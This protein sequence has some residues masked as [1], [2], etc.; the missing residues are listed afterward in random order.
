[1]EST[2]ERILGKFALLIEVA[3]YLHE[4]E[5]MTR[6]SVAKEVREEREAQVVSQYN[7]LVP[8]EKLSSRVRIVHAKTP[9]MMTGATVWNCV[10]EGV[11]TQLEGDLQSYQ[12]NAMGFIAMRMMQ[13]VAASEQYQQYLMVENPAG[14]FDYYVQCMTGVVKSAPQKMWS[15]PRMGAGMLAVLDMTAAQ[16]ERITMIQ[17]WEMIRA[18]L[19]CLQIDFKMNEICGGACSECG[20][21]MISHTQNAMMFCEQ[22]GRTMPIFSDSVEAKHKSSSTNK[23]FN[24]NS[25]CEKHME[26]LQALEADEIPEELVD[27]LYELARRDY[28]RNGVVRSMRGMRCEEVRGWLKRLRRTKYNVHTPKLR[29]LVTARAGEEIVPQRFSDSEKEAIMT[30]FSI[31]ADLFDEVTKD[32]SLLSQINRSEV[33]NH[34]YYPYILYHVL[35]HHI[36]D[37]RRMRLFVDCIHFQSQT[38]LTKNDHIWI[39]IIKQM[40]GYVYE[41][42]KPAEWR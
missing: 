27:K 14:R 8:G 20:G 1:M 41:P 3:A 11:R 31:A 39:N 13:N 26:Y 25:H 9:Y 33:K 30:D 28:C 5:K 38:T 36:K 21:A 24:P 2:H 19:D 23:N 35:N 37:R 29:Q 18:K 17:V 34:P 16:A 12:D 4:V 42:T 6:E 32:T 10:M 15:K 22:C 40:P 7:A